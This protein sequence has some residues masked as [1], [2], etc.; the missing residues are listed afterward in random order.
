MPYAG[1]LNGLFRFL[2]ILDFFG[3]TGNPKIFEILEADEE[4]KSQKFLVVR[5]LPPEQF[6][7][8]IYISFENGLYKFEKEN[9]IFLHIYNMIPFIY[10]NFCTLPN[11]RVDSLRNIS[12][13]IALNTA[14]RNPESLK[15][16]YYFSFFDYLREGW[17]CKRRSFRKI[18]NLFDWD[19]KS[20]APFF[21]CLFYRRF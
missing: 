19:L 4:E 7:R 21:S 14:P 5:P 12:R 13:K 15:I 18:Q 20:R 1:A 10:E 11:R 2:D 16:S 9:L 6:F 17:K 3:K 8:L